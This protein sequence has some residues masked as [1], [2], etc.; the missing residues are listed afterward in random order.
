MLSNLRVS[1]CFIQAI[2][3]TLLLTV[4][5]LSYSANHNRLVEQLGKYSGRES[6]MSETYSYWHFSCLDLRSDQLDAQV[7]AYELDKR[8]NQ[9]ILTNS[10]DPQS[11]YRHLTRLNN[12]GLPNDTAPIVLDRIQEE[13]DKR[14]HIHELHNVPPDIYIVD[15]NTSDFTSTCYS[16]FAVS[17]DA[18]R[19]HLRS[20]T[21][22]IRAWTMDVQN[23]DAQSRRMF[24]YT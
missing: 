4:L 7:K 21:Q 18:V 9:R 10:G 24:E 3:L 15:D 13:E 19:R 8:Y 14:E 17:R 16:Q 12:V 6:I 23:D 5:F 1:R 22:N 11:P 2:S 20:L